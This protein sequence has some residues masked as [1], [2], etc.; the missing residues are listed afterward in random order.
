MAKKRRRS[1]VLLRVIF[2]TMLVG[3]VA[4][5]T[6]CGG[7]DT[8]AS[9]DAAAGDC[10]PGQVRCSLCGGGS[11]CSTGGCPGISCEPPEMDARATDS[12]SSS[13]PDSS[14]DAST[15]PGICS[16]GQVYCPGCYGEPG[17]CSVGGCPGVACPPAMLVG[18][19][20]GMGTCPTIPP[21]TGTSCNTTAVPACCNYQI[22]QS[23][24]GCSCNGMWICK[25]GAMCGCVGQQATDSGHD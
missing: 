9:T 20:G 3:V 14:S 16:P 11:V 13:Q 4:A 8:S 6:S 18:S 5:V 2:G 15:G 19:C 25:V 10:L 12:S 7:D 22:E 17:S 21:G 24:T 23:V 1:A